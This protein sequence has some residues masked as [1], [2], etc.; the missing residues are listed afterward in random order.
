MAWEFEARVATIPAQPMSSAMKA[1]KANVLD[2][3]FTNVWLPC[4]PNQ[5][6]G[7]HSNFALMIPLNERLAELFGNRE[8]VVLA[9]NNV[10][11]KRQTRRLMRCHF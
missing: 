2:S 4:L 10:F 1:E 8:S 6:A 3:V 7:K 5:E 11:R 9:L